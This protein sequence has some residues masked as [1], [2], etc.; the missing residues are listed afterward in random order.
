[1]AGLKKVSTL[2]AQLN[3]EVKS[4]KRYK[5][6]CCYRFYKIQNMCLS[7]KSNIDKNNNKK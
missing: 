3:K 5:V 6:H 7:V 2:F 1:M 4:K